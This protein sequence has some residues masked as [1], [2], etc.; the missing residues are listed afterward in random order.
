MR[1]RA[2]IETNKEKLEEMK[3]PQ[4]TIKKGDYIKV[5]FAGQMLE[6][7]VA[8]ISTDK[9]TNVTGIVLK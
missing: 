4:E 7:E 5:L 1:E 8:V 9:D 3:E 6:G 2:R